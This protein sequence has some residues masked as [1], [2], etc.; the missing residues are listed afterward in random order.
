MSIKKYFKLINYL[1]KFYLVR[2]IFYQ[3]IT[4]EKKL[5]ED[6]INK[7]KIMNWDYNKSLK[8]LNDILENN[9]LNIYDDSKESMI[10]QHLVTFCALKNLKPK[11]ILEIGTYDGQTTFILSKI[12]P[13]AEIITFDLEESSDLFNTSYKR[14]NLEIKK[15]LIKKRENNI[16]NKNIKFITDNSFNIPKYNFSK[17][18]L[19]WVDGDHKYPALSWDICNCF[20]LLNSKGIM[21]CDDIFLNNSDTYNIL[22]YLK[23]EKIFNVDFILK[24]ISKKFSADPFIRKHIAIIMKT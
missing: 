20:H 18:D 22:E 23:N 4:N 1:N 3:K 13:N 19:I 8:I 17:F 7:F 2:S 6:Q 5:L 24:R 12:F 14:S 9:N 21:M 16:N 10:S 11:R 15:L